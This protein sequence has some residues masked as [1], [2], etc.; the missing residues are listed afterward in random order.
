MQTVVPLSRGRAIKLTTSRYYTPSGDSIHDIGITPDI[1]VDDT[2]GY[3]D[4]SLSG[5]L[6]RESDAQLAEAIQQL[7]P[8]PVMHSSA[9]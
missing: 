7:H 5:L 6:D 9:Q 8:R 4:L 3:P 2:Q 1:Y